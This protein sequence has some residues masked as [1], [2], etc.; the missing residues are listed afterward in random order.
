M[1]KHLENLPQRGESQDSARNILQNTQ[2]EGI[3]SM[4]SLAFWGLLIQ[5]A[6]DLKIDQL[7]LTRL[8][9]NEKT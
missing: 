1:H 5:K 2:D 8:N 9:Y 3:L 7:K 6:S 4:G